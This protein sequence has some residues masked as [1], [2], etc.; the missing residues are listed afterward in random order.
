MNGNSQVAANVSLWR[1]ADI[2]LM[3]SISGVYLLLSRFLIGFRPEQ[4]F[5]VG[6]VNLMYFISRGTRKFI[7]GFSIFIIYWIIFDY[8]KAFPNY[9]YATVHIQGLYDLEKSI[10]GIHLDG[11]ILTPNEFWHSHG[12]TILDVLSGCFYLTWIPV[13]LLFASYLFYKNRRLFLYFSLT[14]FL[15]NLIGFVIYYTYPAAPPWYVQQYG[16]VFHEHT[17]GNIAGLGKF[18]QF[19]NVEIFKSLYSKSSNTFAAMPSLHSSYPAIVFYYSLR[20]KMGYKSIF[21]GIIMVGVWFAAVYTGHHYVLDVLAGIACAATGIIL[22]NW[23]VAK[24]I[25]TG[26]IERL[27][28]LTK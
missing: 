22:F 20:N 1:R 12:K 7:T 5:L 18:D 23:L 13:P 2:L 24:N 17:P 3:G 19:F 6:F 9:K 28:K 10:F 21:F 15:V 27:V 8:M 11:L 4:V 16:F 26:F 25:L 14:F